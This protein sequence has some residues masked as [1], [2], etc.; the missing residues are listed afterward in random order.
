MIKNYV[1]TRIILFSI[2]SLL[3]FGNFTSSNQTV[4]NQLAIE[5]S[6]AIHED[7]KLMMM[8][9]IIPGM[10]QKFWK[11]TTGPIIRVLVG[12]YEEWRNI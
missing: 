1:K 10:I 3:L 6:G 7:L 9:I 5:S 4:D 8:E 12:F 11:V 2:L